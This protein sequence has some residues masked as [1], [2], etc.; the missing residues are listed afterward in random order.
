MQAIAY[1][2]ALPF[3]YLI[4]LLPYWL[5][6][7]FSDVIYF[8]LYYIIGYRKEVVMQNLKNSFPE[9]NE[10]ELK[11]LRRK[12]Y[13]YLCDLMLETFQTLTMSRKFSLKRFKLDPKAKD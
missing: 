3:L 5:F 4:S 8:L 9:K 10:K 2:I 6:Y 11:K 7:G 1:Y 13:R 12:F